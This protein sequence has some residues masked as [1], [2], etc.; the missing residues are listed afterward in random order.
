MTWGALKN[1]FPLGLLVA[2]LVLV[3]SSCGATEESEPHP[4]PEDPQALS[5][6]EYRSEEFEP[7]FSFR[8]GKGWSSA[9]LEASDSLLITRVESSAGLGFVNVREVY[10]PT[11][12]GSPNVVDAPEDVVGWF[13][14]HPYLKTSKPEPVMVGGAKGEQLDVVVENLSED[15]SG[16]CGVQC[17]DLFRLNTGSQVSLGEAYKLHL[18]IFRDMK[19]KVVTIGIASPAGY[20][21]E[22][23]PKAE[24]VVDTIEWRDDP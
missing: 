11:R 7:S 19:G 22:F 9:P 17:V 13:Q 8:V 10:D 3:V 24:E 18:I 12:T 1:G 15:H 14:Q 23:A 21:D 5:P 20:F 4:L 2:L 6:G 16:M